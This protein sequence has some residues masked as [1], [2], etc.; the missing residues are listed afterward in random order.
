V[1]AA[2][3]RGLR[4]A[5]T[6]DDRVGEIVNLIDSNGDETNDLC[7]AVSAVVRLSDAEWVPIVLADYP[8]TAAH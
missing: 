3:H 7:E 4:L 5:M 1:I 8:P 2:I 6:E